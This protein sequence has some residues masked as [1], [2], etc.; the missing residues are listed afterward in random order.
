MYSLARMRRDERAAYAAFLGITSGGT[1]GATGIIWSDRS[2]PNSPLDDFLA[3]TVLS[4]DT[5]INLA[6]TPSPPSGHRTNSCGCPVAFSSLQITDRARSHDRPHREQ[7][8]WRA[9]V[10]PV[11]RPCRS[12]RGVR[13]RLRV[14]RS[15]GLFG[16]DRKATEDALWPIGVLA[17]PP[18]T[19]PT[20]D[21]APAARPD[22]RRSAATLI[23]GDSR[24]PVRVARDST[25]GLLW[26]PARSA[27][28]LERYDVAGRIHHRAAIAA[29]LRAAASL[30]SRGAER[31][32]GSPRARDAN[33]LNYSIATPNWSFTLANPG[34]RFEAGE[35]PVIVAIVDSRHRIGDA[36]ATSR[37]PHRTRAKRHRV[38]VRPSD[39]TSH[40]RQRLEWPDVP[41]ASA[42]A[43]Q[44]CGFGCRAGQRRTKSQMA[45]GGISRCDGHQ[46]RPGQR[47]R[48]GIGM[49]R[50]TARR[51]RTLGDRPRA[52]ELGRHRGRGEGATAAR[53]GTRL[54]LDSRRPQR[55][56]R[57]W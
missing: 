27:R 53:G 26:A 12:G 24:Y 52:R 47:R 56:A 34:V 40:V 20:G 46:P 45:G 42:G 33:E 22:R 6:G 11:R 43:R 39:R 7:R 25:Q 17:A 3:T 32:T 41:G 31:H 37:S 2:D 15:G 10:S 49:D 13:D 54:D 1:R 16:A 30:A 8:A 28:S 55:R 50:S 4:P 18:L 23:D 38:R 21:P 36:V 14:Q 57:A 35:E 9:D 51:A 29:R 5:V 48:V 19:G 44:L